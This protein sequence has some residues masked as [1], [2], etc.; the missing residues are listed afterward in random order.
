[1]EIKLD[2]SILEAIN[3]NY[4]IDP[5]VLIEIE[6]RRQTSDAVNSSI[7]DII[8]NSPTA[9]Q[10]PKTTDSPTDQII[11][12]SSYDYNLKDRQLKSILD[13][14]S[15]TDANIDK[16]D[17]VIQKIDGKIVT[18]VNQI[19]QGINEV[20]AA[21]DAKISIGCISNLIWKNI[22]TT[23]GYVAG[24]GS[25]VT[26][27]N[28]IVIKNPVN[29]I[30]Q[31]Y[32][33]LKY[34]QKPSNRDYGFNII[35]EFNG[36]IAVGS[37]TLTVLGVGG[38]TGIQ[39]GDEITDNLSTPIAFSVGNL[40]TVVGFGTTSI[41]GVNTTILGNVSLGSNIIAYT[42]SGSTSNILIGD[43]VI[44][45]SVFDSST[46]VIGFS[47]TTTTI[48]Y[49]NVGSSTIVSIN[50]VVPSIILN[51]VSISSVT[52]GSFGFGTHTQY[53]SLLLST[54]SISAL[55]N[56]SFTAIRRTE[57]ITQNF[58]YANNPSDPITIGVIND[59]QIGV[60]HQVEIVNNG[61]SSGPSQWKKSLDEPEPNIGAGNVTYY[62]GQ[63]LWP[64]ETIVGY[65]SEGN[66]YTFPVTTIPSYTTISPVGLG[67]T[68]PP[69]IDCSSNI[70][71]AESNLQS[72]LNV[73]LP[74]IQKL[75]SA[76]I[77]LRNYRDGD[78]SKAWSYLQSASYLRSDMTKIQS[79]INSLRSFDY[80]SL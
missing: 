54:S 30:T 64:Y 31:N 59:S 14:L 62:S 16:T 34:Y 47:T 23:T 57:D 7:L 78:E 79:D 45:Q 27:S 40:P 71:L 8:K 72:I 2:N 74:E 25:G 13:L 80:N 70:T 52:N 51:K 9:P 44:N 49:Y 28:Y 48:R 38:T 68:S 1:M 53:D 33:G 22:G 18:L 11:N 21:Y 58:N 69:C 36:S 56:K 17:E 4:K 75:V 10:S 24:V 19:N 32:Y 65:A 37:Q 6:Q 61:A 66:T 3:Q 42:G 20:K 77:P 39:I 55:D 5:S 35:S 50:L 12:N 73:N 41:V 43:Y 46:R 15:L 29:S 26:L 67:S 60:G 63:A 76:S